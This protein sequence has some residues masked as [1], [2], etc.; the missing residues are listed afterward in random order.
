MLGWLTRAKFTAGS[1]VIVRH[2]ESILLVKERYRDTTCW[3]LPGGYWRRRE[4]PLNAAKRELAEETGLKY[5]DLEFVWIY[6]Q[7]GTLH[8]DALYLLQIRGQRPDARSTSHELSAARWARYDE[9]YE[10]SLTPETKRALW[11]LERAEHPTVDIPT[12]EAAS[13]IFDA[14]NAD[15]ARGLDAGGQISTALEDGS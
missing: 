15:H 14:S 11:V 4:S 5:N 8:L 13:Q 2:E 3:G 1:L 9:L 10:L 7:P 6:P 12:E